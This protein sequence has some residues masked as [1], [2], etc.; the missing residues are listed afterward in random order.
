MP[1]Y[2]HNPNIREPQ[3]EPEFEYA[4]KGTTAE[5]TRLRQFKA[6]VLPILEAV[7]DGKCCKA[8]FD[9]LTNTFIGISHRLKKEAANLLAKRGKG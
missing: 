5:L 7:R 3:D 9:I 8:Q 1:Q 6:K 4:I 2:P